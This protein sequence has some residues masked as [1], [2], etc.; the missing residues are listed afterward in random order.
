[1]GM[2]GG[3]Q[4]KRAEMLWIWEIFGSVI[5]SGE[6]PSFQLTRIMHDIVLR[7]L[8]K[9]FFGKTFCAMVSLG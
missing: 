1:M 7:K 2:G 4:V 3:L 6:K 9:Q 8:D 5:S